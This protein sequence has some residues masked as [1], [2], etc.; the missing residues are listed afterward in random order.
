MLGDT[1]TGPIMFECVS[2]YMSVYVASSVTSILC[3][4][5]HVPTCWIY[6][7]VYLNIHT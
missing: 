2:V 3:T 6:I 7:Y 1:I 4:H 5:M